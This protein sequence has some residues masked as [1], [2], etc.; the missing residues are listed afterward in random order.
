MCVT[1]VYRW[2]RKKYNDCTIKRK[3][4]RTGYEECS[5]LNSNLAFEH[6]PRLTEFQLEFSLFFSVFNKT[7]GKVLILRYLFLQA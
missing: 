7:S 1:S 3:L 2:F 5:A 4:F 6:I